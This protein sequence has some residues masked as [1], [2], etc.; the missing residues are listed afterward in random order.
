MISAIMDLCSRM[1]EEP[2]RLQLVFSNLGRP[3]EM[4][5]HKH[6]SLIQF[7]FFSGFTGSVELDG[8]RSKISERFAFVALPGQV[9][10]FSVSP[11]SRSPINFSIRLRVR[12]EKRDWSERVP[13][14]PVASGDEVSPDLARTLEQL[15]RLFHSSSGRSPVCIA[16]LTEVLTLWPS[17]AETAVEHGILAI[18]RQDSVRVNA[19]IDYIEAHLGERLTIEDL[20]EHLALSTRHVQRLFATAM[21]QSPSQYRESR[22]VSLACDLIVE[23]LA[24][25]DVANRLGYESIHSFSRWFHSAKGMT[26][27]EYRSLWTE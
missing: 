4:P 14:S 23:G 1:F 25:S 3:V 20:A 26:A 6:P 5:K 10:S 8:E 22:R 2:D 12:D 18:G 11:V 27:S 19:A 21:G 15:Y 13:F 16:K 9:H 17:V 7:D 24:F